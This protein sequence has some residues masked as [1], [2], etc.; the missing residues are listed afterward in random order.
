MVAL[1]VA[2]MSLPSYAHRFSPRLYTQ[3]QLFACL[4]LKVFFNPQELLSGLIR[5]V[6]WEQPPN[7]RSPK[8]TL[9][10]I[11]NDLKNLVELK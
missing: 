8:R 2:E 6:K 11:G 1:K 4:A 7:K 10:Q 3:S 5:F 9:S